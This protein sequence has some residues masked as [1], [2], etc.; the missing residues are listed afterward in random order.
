MLLKRLFIWKNTNP[1]VLFLIDGVGALL[2]AFL[3]GIVLV[4]F[5][6]IFGIPKSTLYFLASLPSLFAI[7]DFYCFF[8][9]NNKLANYLYRIAFINLIYCCISIG[10]AVYHN[11]EITELGWTYILIEVLVI[12]ALAIFELVTAKL[13]IRESNVNRAN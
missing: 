4:K 10:L 2:S 3:L 5:E 8:W 9:L 12:I 7:Y 6:T 11:N 1:R 13:L